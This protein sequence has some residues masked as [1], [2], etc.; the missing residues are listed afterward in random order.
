MDKVL[1]LGSNSFTGYHFKKFIK[2]NELCKNFYFIT[3]D[4][5][6]TQNYAYDEIE[7]LQMNVLN[8]DELKN[9]LI[10]QEPDYIINLIGTFYAASYEEYFNV[11]A[12]IAKDIFETILKNNLKVKKV[13]LI[14]SA[15]EYG[16]VNLL[17]VGEDSATNPVNLYGISKL[18]QTHIAKYYFNSYGIN[19]NVARTFNI[20][21]KG[22][23]KKLSIGNFIE[24]INN[25]KDGDTI[26]T[27]NLKSR[28]DYLYIDDVIEAYWNI[29]TNGHNGE[30]YNVCSAKSLSMEE[31]LIHLINGSGKALNIKTDETLIKNNDINEVYGD[32]SKLI[33]HTGWC[34]KHDILSEQVIGELV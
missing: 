29:L 28:R 8:Q 19:M 9:I 32:N 17:P 14:G 26:L 3:T 22:I 18:M 11:N 4:R 13:L 15:A 1:L 30:I 21:G 2:Q 27:G 34:L 16:N 20:I 6:A 10:T 31:I 5:E 7:Y 33:N 23:S 25:A 24:Q 12:N